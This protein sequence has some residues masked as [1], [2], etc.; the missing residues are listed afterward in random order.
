MAEIVC[1]VC[2]HRWPL[3]DATTNRCPNCDAVVEIYYDA[4]EAERVAQVY[5]G[6]RANGQPRSGVRSLLG[7]NGFA[8]AFPDSG[9]LAEIAER[10]IRGA[11]G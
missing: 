11:R 1:A 3:G 5:N 2:N 7:I 10:L 4:A 8:V 6:E 9:R